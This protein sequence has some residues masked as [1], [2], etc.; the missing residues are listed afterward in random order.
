MVIL[1]KFKCYNSE[2]KLIMPGFI[3]ASL[4]PLLITTTKS[5]LTGC[6]NYSLTSEFKMDYNP[7]KGFMKALFDKTRIYK[8]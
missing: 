2:M 7:K 4:L 6:L 1:S 5:T 8:F 3:S